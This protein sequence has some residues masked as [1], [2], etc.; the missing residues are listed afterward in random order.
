M[1]NPFHT[2]NLMLMDIHIDTA[3]EYPLITYVYIR[4][5][6][7]KEIRKTYSAYNMQLTMERE[8]PFTTLSTHFDT[9]IKLEGIHLLSEEIIDL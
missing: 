3:N 2:D 6:D 8:N 7:K 9:E 1:T 4:P 5:K